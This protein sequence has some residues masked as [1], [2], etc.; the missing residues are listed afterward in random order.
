MA[1]RIEPEGSFEDQL[2]Y[3]IAHPTSKAY[4]AMVVALVQAGI[5]AAYVPLW[6]VLVW[7]LAMNSANVVWMVVTTRAA[8]HTHRDSH[9]RLGWVVKASLLTGSLAGISNGAFAWMPEMERA[10]F[11]MITSAWPAAPRRRF[12]GIGK[13][14]WP[15][16]CQRLVCS[17]S[18]GP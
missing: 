11:S 14:S 2:L 8:S 17:L 7:L 6:I 10:V 4:A 3:G 1:E 18:P 16:T 15:I 5:A 9:Q 13:A 12:M